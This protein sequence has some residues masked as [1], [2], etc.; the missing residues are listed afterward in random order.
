MAQQENLEFKNHKRCDM[1]KKFNISMLL[2][3][4]TLCIVSFFLD[5]RISLLAMSSK[6]RF[7]DML[8]G[9]I[10]NFIFVTLIVLLVPSLLLYKKEKK[11]VYLFWFAFIATIIINVIAKL[12]IHRNRPSEPGS[13]FIY[14]LQQ[15]SFPSTHTVVVFSMLPFLIKYLP[16]QKY[17]WIFFAFLVGF[18]RLYFNYHFFS[19][20][21]FG[22]FFGYLIGI[23]FLH[24]D[25]R[26][27]LWKK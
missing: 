22:A 6:I 7:L 8:F 20:V 18:T 12:I 21:A 10:T 16:R 14:S 13:Y 9:I 1:M 5:D 25:E 2:I 19:D 4:I 17:F 24:L 3:L 11:T 15:Y 23:F 27:K 26:G